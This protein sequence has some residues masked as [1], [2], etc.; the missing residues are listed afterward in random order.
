MEIIDPRQ[1]VTGEFY[2][3]QRNIFQNANIFQHFWRLAIFGFI[4]ISFNKFSKT[5]KMLWKKG[6]FVN[7]C[8]YIQAESDE[9]ARFCWYVVSFLLIWGTWG[10]F[11]ED[12]S[13]IG[14]KFMNFSQ[15]NRLND[16]HYNAGETVSSDFFYNGLRWFSNFHYVLHWFFRMIH[17]H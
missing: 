13:N 14:L 1:T 5:Q 17:S 4:L 7:F 11:F 8:S 9:I 10:S 2:I 6:I 15:K 12:L 16:F 3:F